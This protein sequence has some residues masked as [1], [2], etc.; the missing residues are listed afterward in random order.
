MTAKRLLHVTALGCLAIATFWS[1]GDGERED[2]N[3][4]TLNSASVSESADSKARLSPQVEYQALKC[5]LLRFA[6][7]ADLDARYEALL[8]NLPHGQYADWSMVA[9]SRV[10]TAG[11]A[12]PE[13]GMQF[14]QILVEFTNASTARTR[15]DIPPAQEDGL[16]LALVLPAGREISAWE[17]IGSGWFPSY[18]ATEQYLARHGDQIALRMSF[19][20][21]LFCELEPGQRAWLALVFPLPDN[22]N[23]ALSGLTLRL[24]SSTIKIPGL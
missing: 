21:Q 11:I 22:P 16:D 18:R 5:G 23:T 24:G 20:G 19:T 4:R 17:F 7:L 9:G 1:C 10:S 8:S 3:A 13:D 14:A 12:L 15:L 2:S 6:G